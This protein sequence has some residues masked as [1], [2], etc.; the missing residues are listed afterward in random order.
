MNYDWNVI[1]QEYI[2]TES[3]SYRKL[4][5]KYGISYTSIGNRARAEGWAEQREQ[6][7]N[8]TLSKSLKALSKNQA[9]R[10]K[11]IQDVADKVLDKIEKA[12][13]DFSMKELMFDKQVLKQITGALRDIKD[14]QMIKSDADMREQEARIRN[15][16]KQAETDDTSKDITVTIVGDLEEYSK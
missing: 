1:R 4:A 15:L 10:A 7:L 16:Q 9:E 6:Y 11:R 13:D 12:V 8:E 2:T 5:E 14:I 3:A